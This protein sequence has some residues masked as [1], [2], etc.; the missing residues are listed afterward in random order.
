METVYR[1]YAPQGVKFYYIYKSLAHPEINGFV[2]PI[3][4][5][6][7]LKHVQEA[8]RRLGTEF[9]WL[10]DSM[11]ND[12]KHVLGNAPNSEFVIDPEGKVIRRRNWSRPAELRKDLEEL[13]GPVEKPT[14]VADL[15][16]KI[17]VP[18]KAAASGI[19]PRIEKPARLEPVKVKPQKNNEPFYVKLRAEV[20]RDLIG[21]GEGQVY[22]AF[23]LDPIYQV[24]W[25][26]LAP[27]I[28]FRIDVPD[29]VTV[30]TA[31][32]EGPKVEEAADIDPR[33]FLLTMKTPADFDSPLKLRV[34][35]YACND[36]EGWCKQITQEYEILLVADRDAGRA[37]S[38]RRRPSGSPGSG[39]RTPPRPD[40]APGRP[41]TEAEF[42]KR[43]TGYDRNKDGKVADDELPGF[44][45][46]LL[47]RGDSNKDGVL[48]QDEIKRV[49]KQLANRKRAE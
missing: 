40:A 5:E 29:G 34:E 42:V 9:T 16:L 48:D 37:M 43:I 7:R 4:L 38:F 14:Q 27:A 33:E 20:E 26:N 36:E 22:L 47:R 15:D 31:E 24:H 8:K 1:D 17:E 41:N 21:G 3:T 19:V 45:K 25:N 23:H 39:R 32:G 11:A 6:E 12:A 13:V 49:A 2:Q 28:K 10:A 46:N 30:D 35:Y 44:R 18:P